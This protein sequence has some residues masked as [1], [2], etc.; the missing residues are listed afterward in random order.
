[1]YVYF[2][3][4]GTKTR[5]AVSHDGTSF[6][7]PQK[8]ETPK[9]FEDLLA[10]IHD[11]ARKLGGDGPIIAAGGGI[12]CP[13]D[14]D[15]NS[16]LCWAPNL[17]EAWF[18]HSLVDELGGVLGAP[19]FVDNDTDVIGIGKAHHG[20]GQGYDIMVYLT[21]STG[22]GGARIV[23]GKGED[24]GVSAE[25]GRQFV[26]FDKTA[27]PTCEDA[28]MLGYAS[29]AATERRFGKKPYDVSDSAVWEDMAKWC[30]YMLNNTI[31][32]WAPN[33]VVLGGS[34]IIGDPAIPV[35]RIQKHLA[36]ILTYP[37]MPDIKKA[38]LGDFGGIY[39]AMEF[40]RQKLEAR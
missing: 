29:G 1:M 6:E 3:I 4:G 14:R 15:Q 33:A 36:P 8:F 31:L 23:H 19:V 30:A 27:C 32:H 5:V 9:R 12:A 11:T 40:V 39:G 10:A 38:E 13:V 37:R 22:V 25:P 21:V 34:M 18:A 28:S 35:D 24:F 17:P 20:A 26:D 2:D 7:Q 16:K